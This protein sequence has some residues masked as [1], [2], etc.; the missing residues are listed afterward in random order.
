VREL[1]RLFKILGAILL[2][3][4]GSFLGSVAY[5]ESFGNININYILMF[6]SFGLVIGGIIYF[7]HIAKN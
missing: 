5:G 4:M 2:F 3:C 7:I 1:K 6:L